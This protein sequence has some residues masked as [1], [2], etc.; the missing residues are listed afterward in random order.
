MLVL[1]RQWFQCSLLSV[2]RGFSEWAAR[3]VRHIVKTEGALSWLG[4]LL[5]EI[6]LYRTLFI[7]PA[8]TVRAERQDKHDVSWPSQKG[9]RRGGGGEKG[10]MR[11]NS[12]LPLHYEPTK[13]DRKGTQNP[14]PEKGPKKIQKQN[15]ERGPGIQPWALSH[16]YR[17]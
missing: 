6:A 17:Q 7:L 10:G 1:N 2:L 14:N 16:V 12:K 9:P 11:F 4:Y 3:F 5:S 8:A 15:Q 13:P